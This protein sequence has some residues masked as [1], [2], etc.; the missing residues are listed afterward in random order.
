MII[1]I[2]HIYF[3]TNIA[4]VRTQILNFIEFVARKTVLNFKL[5]LENQAF[6]YKH[7]EHTNNIIKL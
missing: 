6:K 2:V 1:V 5:L 4:S 7:L 3:F